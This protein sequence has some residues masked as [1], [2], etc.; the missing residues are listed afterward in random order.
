MKTHYSFTT[1]FKPSSQSGMVS[2]GH[3]FSVLSQG[4]SW[5]IIFFTYNKIP[6]N[7]FRNDNKQEDNSFER[8]PKM[9]CTKPTVEK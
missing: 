3:V 6:P 7:I 8:R 9:N 2:V 5:L 1:S 4:S